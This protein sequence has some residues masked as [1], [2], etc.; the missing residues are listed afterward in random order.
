VS[1]FFRSIFNVV[2]QSTYTLAAMVAALLLKDK[3]AKIIGYSFVITAGFDS[4]NSFI[5]PLLYTYYN[6]VDIPLYV[7]AFV[8]LII[9]FCCL[10]LVFVIKMN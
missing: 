6:N 8:C 4:L 7:G 2:A 3:A 10:Y 5:T 1:M 9:F